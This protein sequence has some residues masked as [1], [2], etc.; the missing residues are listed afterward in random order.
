MLHDGEISEDVSQEAAMGVGATAAHQVIESS[1]TVAS[2]VAAG[3]QATATQAA[4]G[5]A[6][7]AAAVAEGAKNTADAAAEGAQAAAKEAAAGAQAT[8]ETGGDSMKASADTFV[9]ELTRLG[10]QVA[11]SAKSALES[12]QAKETQANVTNALSGLALSIEEQVKKLAEREDVKRAVQQVETSA[13]TLIESIATN[14][15]VQDVAAGIMKGLGSAANQLTAWLSQQSQAEPQS[16]GGFGGPE[17][18]REV[19]DVQEIKVK[20]EG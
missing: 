12:P 15:A 20:K 5:A 4:M 17:A 1:K 8:A 7:T 14:K 16:G 13:D 10:A 19:E 6:A 9:D 11:A 18:S 2:S 3:A